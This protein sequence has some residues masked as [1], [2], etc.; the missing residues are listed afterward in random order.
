M[1]KWASGFQCVQRAHEMDPTVM[2]MSSWAEHGP[3]E[4]RSRTTPSPE[5]LSPSA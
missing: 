5:L 2:C 4:A 1:G 3:R